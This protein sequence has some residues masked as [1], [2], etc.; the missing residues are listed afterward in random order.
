MPIILRSGIVPKRENAPAPYADAPITRPP[1]AGTRA[2]LN[3]TFAPNLDIRQR[4]AG[5]TLPIRAKG[6]PLRIG[7]D[8]HPAQKGKSELEW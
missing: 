1:I 6:G 3:V 8:E 4:T 2:N 5:E 7:I